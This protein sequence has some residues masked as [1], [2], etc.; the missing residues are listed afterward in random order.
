MT[1][2]ANLSSWGPT[3]PQP[4]SFVRRFRWLLIG[5]GL[6]V[7]LLLLVMLAPMLASMG[8]AKSIIL[9]QVK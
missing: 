7:L 2:A 9:G 6:V 5:G 8:W 4:K 3:T 1:V